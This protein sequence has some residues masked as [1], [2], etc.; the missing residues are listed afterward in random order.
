MRTIVIALLFSLGILTVSCLPTKQES[1][2]TTKSGLAQGVTPQVENQ[3]SEAYKDF[4]NKVRSVRAAGQIDQLLFELD[5]KY[6]DPKTPVEVKFFAAQMIP[7]RQFRSLVY[8]MVPL[9]QKDYDMSRSNPATNATHHAAVT[10]VMMAVSG[11]RILVPYAGAATDYL[12]KPL[13]LNP[14]FDKRTTDI[15]GK[16]AEAVEQ[17]ISTSVFQNRFVCTD[18]RK[19]LEKAIARISALDFGEGHVTV[20]LAL[21]FGQNAVKTAF[22]Q[23]D[24]NKD[25]YVLVGEPERAATLSGM[26]T[27]MHNLNLAC[28]Y[29]MNDVT[30]VVEAL[31]LSAGMD[32]IIDRRAVRGAPASI[33]HSLLRTGRIAAGGTIRERLVQKSKDGK[34]MG[35]RMMNAGVLRPNTNN[36]LT[37]ALAFMKASVFYGNLAYYKA[38]ARGGSADMY[39][40]LDFKRWEPVDRW[41]RLLAAKSQDFAGIKE[42]EVAAN[43]KVPPHVA[44]FKKMKDRANEGRTVMFKSLVTNEA[45][46]VFVDKVYLRPPG[47]V[48]DLLPTGFNTNNEFFAVNGG[49]SFGLGI[50]NKGKKP[51]PVGN[52]NA[53]NYEW[54]MA[55]R[56]PAR[57][58]SYFQGGGDVAKNIRILSESVGGQPIAAA[59]AP[60]VF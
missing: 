9:F 6:D 43:Q 12:T 53:R 29:S 46:E 16:E 8:K 7:L 45:V 60:F 48:R 51:R 49:Q 33:R 22:T 5:E 58:G 23:G 2:S 47:N 55:T 59:M 25:R 35:Q 4:A 34:T 31:G 15:N 14:K 54:G 21:A 37:D 30:Y 36:L 50:L 1:I 3:R 19:D 27:A 17:Y 24:H 26:M 52:G 41:A 40:V 18:F 39:P 20:D 28:A 42:S 44:V 57:F 56:W 32:G 38:R 13:T 10:A 11:Q